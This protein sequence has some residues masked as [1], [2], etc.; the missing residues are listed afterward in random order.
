MEATHKTIDWN[1]SDILMQ[2]AQH[3]QHPLA[4]IIEANK[5]AAEVKND[6]KQENVSE[7][8]FSNSQEIS[9]LIKEVTDIARSRSIQI[10]KK[11]Q[12]IIFD[13]YNTN[14]K[15]KHLCKKAIQPNSM[16]ITDHHWLVNFETEVFDEIKSNQVNLQDLSYKLAISERQLHRKIKNLLHLTPNKYIRILKLHK[17][18]ELLS[19]FMY[20]TVS[21][22]AYAVGYYD[23]H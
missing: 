10:S 11:Q 6:E 19:K 13:I 17:A 14:P 20:N 22:V 3:L 21:E 8:I 9:R 15:V 1:S 23:T 16:S 4:S 5:R 7:I 12:P 2:I 18:K